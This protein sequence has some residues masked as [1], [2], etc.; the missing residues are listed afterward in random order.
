MALLALSSTPAKEAQAGSLMQKG[1]KIILRPSQL[2]RFHPVLNGSSLGK[3]TTG[4]SC[5]G[6]R[7]CCRR[8]RRRWP[9]GVI[10][11]RSRSCASCRLASCERK[12]LA[13]ITISPSLVSRRPASLSKRAR[14]PRATKGLPRVE[15]QL[16]GCRHL[17]D[18]LAAR[19]GCPT[20]VSESSLRRSRHRFRF[21]SWAWG[22]RPS[23]NRPPEFA[24]PAPAVTILPCPANWTGER[25]P[26]MMAGG[27]AAGRRAL[28][29]NCARSARAVGMWQAS[30]ARMA[31]VPRSGHCSIATR[32]RCGRSTGSMRCACS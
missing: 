1:G 4:F 21:Q 31:A 15:A 6:R 32:Q 11:A 30:L 12:R 5:H 25:R 2:A 28:R 14:S 23:A 20:K 24:R 8:G 9:L 27:G 16:H 18:V 17:V 13:T 26:R 3:P 29:R 19:S 10:R 22:N 7:R